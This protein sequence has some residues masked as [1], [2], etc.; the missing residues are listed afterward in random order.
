MCA[1][2]ALGGRIYVIFRIKERGIKLPN[3][4]T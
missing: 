2:K 3:L 1:V 4:G